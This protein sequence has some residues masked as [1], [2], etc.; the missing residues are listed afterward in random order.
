MAG[1]GSD[2]SD[3]N[4]APAD[5]LS[6]PPGH[7]DAT[8][9][10]PACWEG[11]L[12]ERVAAYEA[13]MER[14]AGAML[15][16]QRAGARDLTVQPVRGALTY[17]WGL[18]ELTVA[19]CA[20]WYVCTSSDLNDTFRGRYEAKLG[21]VVMA[22]VETFRRGRSLLRRPAEHVR[23]DD[24]RSPVL[25][26][27]SFSSD[28]L[29]KP[30]S[31]GAWPGDPYTP[32]AALARAFGQIAPVVA[33]HDNSEEFKPGGAARLSVSGDVW[34]ASVLALMREA[35]I[36]IFDCTTLSDGLRWEVEQA[37]NTFGLPPERVLVYFPGLPFET[38]EY[39]Q[40][41]YQ[42]HGAR[43]AALFPKGLPDLIGDA[44]IY[45]AFDGDWTP[46]RL[47]CPAVPLWRSRERMIADGA[48]TYVKNVLASV[49]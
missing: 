26:L 45:I 10:L 48:A 19:V 43:A 18:A 16:T 12:A 33:L 44:T 31:T 47:P 14:R 13:E 15:T 17:A 9:D 3:L 30:R 6:A 7:T 42:T 27:R 4:S 40:Y 5:R 38:R 21:V 32:E 34:R 24:Q 2:R 8:D 20:A 22:A 11:T 39:R 23:R 41:R 36:V 28:R 49:R 25:L 1:V 46:R 29:Q 37:V 35:Q